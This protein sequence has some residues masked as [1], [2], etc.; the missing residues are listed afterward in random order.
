M[1]GIND[2]IWLQKKIIKSVLSA[3]E[4]QPL[5]FSV[6]HLINF[7]PSLYFESAC[8]MGLLHTAHQ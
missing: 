8:E 5:L 1:E 7:L 3:S 6:L 4:L 2:T